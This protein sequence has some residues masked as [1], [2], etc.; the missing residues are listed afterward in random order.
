M[1]KKNHYSLQMG[2][3]SLYGGEIWRIQA[4]KVNRNNNGT[5]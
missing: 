1:E 4:I 3:L 5:I 2:K